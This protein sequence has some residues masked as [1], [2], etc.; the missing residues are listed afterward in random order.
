MPA[1]SMNGSCVTGTLYI[2]SATDSSYVYS[3]PAPGGFITAWSTNT[4]ADTAGA[5]VTLVVLR[6]GG[7]QYA[8]VAVDSETMPTPL[9]SSGVATFSP[10]QPISVATGDT[11][12][13]W[14]SSPSF[15]CAW[16]MGSIP[17]GE[18]V[19][20]AT[21]ATAPST[22]A[23]YTSIESAPNALLNVS[24]NLSQIQDVAVTGA[25]VPASIAAGGAAEYVF[26]VG[27][28][29]PLNGTITLTDTVPL[30][31]KILAAI[32][33]SGT[34]AVVGQVVTCTLT[35]LAAGSTA[36]VGI[37]VSAATAGSYPDTA[38]VAGQVTDPT[39]ADNSASATLTV[40]LVSD[41]VCR[42]VSLKGAPL[43]VAKAVIPALNCALGKTTKKPSKQIRKGLVMSTSPGPGKNVANGTKVNIV[44][45]SGPPKRKKKKK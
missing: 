30:G 27:N 7:G 31:L 41:P 32:P 37:I 9:P 19:S 13:L 39:P 4:A 12:A 26:T 43:A 44:V 35:G 45:S 24:A 38:T 33:A 3:V 29:G 36:P 16:A 10:T 8:V 25:A 23:Q 18:V 15:S 14:S 42:V 28:G 5:N 17:A 21:A 34:C 20:G 1:S 2:Q 22:G 40:S 11:L 6:P